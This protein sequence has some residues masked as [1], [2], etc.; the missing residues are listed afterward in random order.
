MTHSRWSRAFAVLT[1]MIL[2]ASGAVQ[3]LPLPGAWTAQAG[4]EPGLLGLLRQVLTS[5]WSAGDNGSQLDPSGSTVDNGSQLDPDGATSNGDNG[6][7]L[8]P[9]G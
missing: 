4:S 6:S 1:L 7:Q 2:L 8:D 9:N 3:A 5:I